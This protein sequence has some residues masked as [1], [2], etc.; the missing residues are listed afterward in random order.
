MKCRG[1][2]IEWPA[3]H[4]ELRAGLCINNVRRNQPG[5]G[6]VSLKDSPANSPILNPDFMRSYSAFPILATT[7]MTGEND[8]IVLWLFYTKRGLLAP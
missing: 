7:E 1:H 5:G 6:T 3:T 2:D 8:F 4:I